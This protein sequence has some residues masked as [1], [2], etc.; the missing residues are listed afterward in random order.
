MSTNRL[1]SALYAV[2]GFCGQHTLPRR[3]S[4]DIIF[5]NMDSFALSAGYKMRGDTSLRATDNLHIA[6]YGCIFFFFVYWF[7]WSNTHEPSWSRAQSCVDGPGEGRS[8]STGLNGLYIRLAPTDREPI[9]RLIDLFIDC[10]W[11]FRRRA[12]IRCCR[13][14]VGNCRKIPR[15]G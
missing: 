15:K 5:V 13:R 11:A 6:G 14:G 8:S 1:R 7:G 3:G 2:F 12:T 10:S 4:F 9:P